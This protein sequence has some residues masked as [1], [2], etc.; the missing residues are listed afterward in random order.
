MFNQYTF[1]AIDGLQS[2]Q[3]QFVSTFVQHEGFKK[4]LTSFVDAQVEYT[5]SAITANTDV[6]T[7]TTEILMDRTPYVDFAEKISSYFPT[8]KKAK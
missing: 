1:Q 7:K 8:G 4:V 2:A 3:K 6:F 5:K